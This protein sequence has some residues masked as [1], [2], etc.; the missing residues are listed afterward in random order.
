MKNLLFFIHPSIFSSYYSTNLKAKK[1]I[2][3]QS[4]LICV[5]VKYLT[6]LHGYD[7]I[8][9]SKQT[10]RNGWS[11]TSAPISLSLYNQFQTSTTNTYKMTVFALFFHIT[12]FKKAKK[13]KQNIIFIL[14]TYSYSS[15]SYSYFSS[16][17]K[18][19]IFHNHN[20]HGKLFLLIFSYIKVRNTQS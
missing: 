9:I 14:N 2:I 8:R 17:R 20:M 16:E 13:K 19:K 12:M 6:R 4:L 15:Y 3:T 10:H 5:M 18:Q 7:V 11:H 1:N